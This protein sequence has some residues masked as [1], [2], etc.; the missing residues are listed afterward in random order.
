MD[1]IAKFTATEPLNSNISRFAQGL[2]LQLSAILTHRLGEEWDARAAAIADWF[3]PGGP[4][5]ATGAGSADSK[6]EAGVSAASGAATTGAGVAAAV[7]GS[8]ANVPPQA[9]RYHDAK[10]FPELNAQRVPADLC[11]VAAAQEGAGMGG[12]ADAGPSA[13][14]GVSAASAADGGAA[15][16]AAAASAADGG[17]A[18]SAAAAAAWEEEEE[19]V[20][21][22]DESPSP[23]GDDPG[24]T[25]EDIG[26]TP[27]LSTFTGIDQ[28]GFLDLAPMA[29]IFGASVDV[30]EAAVAQA[31]VAGMQA[32]SIDISVPA[33][34]AYMR[35][36]RV[37]FTN[38][39]RRRANF[40]RRFAADDIDKSTV[41]VFM[42][43]HRDAFNKS[44]GQRRSCALD[45]GNGMAQ[46]QVKAR[47][48][49]RFNSM[50]QELYGG[51]RALRA[52]LLTGRFADLRL[53]PLGRNP[54]GVRLPMPQPRARPNGAERRAK[55]YS[56]LAA[57][58][59]DYAQT[60]EARNPHRTTRL[61]E[62][63]LPQARSRA[64]GRGWGGRQP[65][66]EFH[67]D[68]RHRWR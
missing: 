23:R 9:P 25:L 39:A 33:V 52:Y 40:L 56:R 13:E 26:W 38:M 31:A 47:L 46:H 20:D 10:A 63:F 4:A 62:E 15:S 50:L 58:L 32:R 42:R 1:R 7:A 6:T 68:K 16:S 8:L 45:R 11:D 54:E 44:E 29:W 53:P 22:N 66:E 48:A 60:G 19:E 5:D 2:A 14:A 41:E 12:G 21:W 34:L 64:H 18:S 59:D 35:Q 27:G 17:A 55:Y 67:Q 65:R 28:Q 51:R 36:M 37:Q 30:N 57:D 43:E 49:A 24:P 3:A 61:W